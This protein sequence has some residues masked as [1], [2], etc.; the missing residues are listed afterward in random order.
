MH[1]DRFTSYLWYC[2]STYHSTLTCSTYHSTLNCSTYHSTLTYFQIF[3]IQL[4]FKFRLSLYLEKKTIVF[5]LSKFIANW[6][7]RTE[8]GKRRN[9]L[10]DKCFYFRVCVLL[11]HFKANFI[12]F[13]IG[14]LFAQKVI[15]NNTVLCL[16]SFLT[17]H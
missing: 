11:W 6:T 12:I 9:V 2:K 5:H 17:D 16:L 10:T 8:W 13:F 7:L 3:I 1:Y 14:Q 4:P 15:S